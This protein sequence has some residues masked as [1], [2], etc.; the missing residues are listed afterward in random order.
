[1]WPDKTLRCLLKDNYNNLVWVE[2]FHKTEY[3]SFRSTMRKNDELVM[4]DD[5]AN[6]K[7]QK[8]LCTVMK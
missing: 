6:K 5:E 4:S 2:S 8:P 3:K 7:P 1:M